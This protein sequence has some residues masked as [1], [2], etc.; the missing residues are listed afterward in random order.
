MILD[1]MQVYAVL[2]MQIYAYNVFG[3]KHFQQYFL[4]ILIF[5][6]LKLSREK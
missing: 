6:A 2:D 3:D 4:E 5:K 1:D